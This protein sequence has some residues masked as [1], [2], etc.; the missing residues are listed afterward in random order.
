M[1]TFSSPGGRSYVTVKASRPDPASRYH[2]TISDG[3][4]TG[5]SGLVDLGKWLQQLGKEFAKEEG[6]DAPDLVTQLAPSLKGGT[7]V[8][9]SKTPASEEGATTE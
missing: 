8:V 3:F 1:K 9:V 2:I 4:Y 7:K 5:A 6:G